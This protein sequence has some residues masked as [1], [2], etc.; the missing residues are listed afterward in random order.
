MKRSLC[1]LVLLS[2]LIQAETIL[3]RPYHGD[4]FLFTQPDGTSFP[5]RLYGDEYYAVVETPDGYTLTRDP[6]T[7]F[8]SYALPTPG[9][10]SFHPSGFPPTAPPPENLS[11]QKHLRL[12]PIVVREESRQARERFGVDDRGRL[13]PHLRVRLRPRDYGYERW[14]PAL[15]AAA[16]A[17]AAGSPAPMAPPAFPTTGNRVGLVL[18][19]RFPDRPGDVTISQAE[20]DAFVNDPG[21]TGFDN[22]TSVYGYFRLQSGGRL[23]YNSI[24]TA[25]FTAAQPRAYYTDPA[26]PYGTRARELINEG[27]AVLKANGFD[28]TRADGNGDGV[29]D[30]VNIFYAGDVVNNWAEGLWPHKSSSSWPGLSGEGVSQAFQYQITHL[31]SSLTLGAYCH[32]NGHMLCDFPDLYPYDDNAADLGGYSLMHS[33]GTIHPP[34]LDAYLKINA[35]WAT[36]IDLDAASHLRGA[37][38]VDTNTFY[39]FRNPLRP[40]EYF[41]VSLRTNSGYEGIYGGAATE[42]NPTDGIVLWHALETGS[43]TNSS[44]RTVDNPLADYSVPYEL[45]VV[46]A[47]PDSTLAR[48]YDEPMPGLNDG[49]VAGGN[50]EASDSTF[51]ALRFWDPDGRTI[52]SGAHV[53]SVS[54]SG[55]AMT[56]VAGSG[57]PAGTPEIGLTVAELTP[58]CDYGVNAAEQSFAIFNGGGGTLSYTLSESLPWLSLSRS[59][60]S[61]TS[62][63]D[64]VTVN[65]ATDSLGAGTYNG[66]I[67]VTG[68]AAGNSP[69]AL[70]V[71]LTVHPQPAISLSTAT[72]STTLA[73]GARGEASFTIANP[74]GGTLHY[75]LSD[76]ASWLGLGASGGTV[77]AE[78]DEITVFYDTSGLFEGVYPAV[79]TVDSSDAANAPQ[80]IDVTLTVTGHVAVTGPDG[81]ETLWRGNLHDIAWQTDGSVT[82]DVRIDLY[83]GGSPAETLAAATP[84]DG[85]F[86]WEIPFTLAAGDDYR[87]R[88]SAVSD[89]LLAGESEG[90]FSISNP[91]SLVPVP[92]REGFEYGFGTW[93]QPADDW[94]DWTRQ[95]GSTPSLNTGPAGA[96]AGNW[97]L[98]VE[99]S[100]PNYPNKTAVLEGFFD[101]R[102]VTDPKLSFFYHMFGADMGSLEAAVS[103]DQ[104]SWTT[105]FSKSGD[106]GDGWRNA[107]ID[108][109]SFAGRAVSIRITG[110]TGPGYTSDIALDTISLTGQTDPFPWYLFLPAINRGSP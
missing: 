72:L 106:Q 86:E 24:V 7:G 22:A 19:A 45:L 84:N 41:L 35:G 96:Q 64:V 89:P 83:K 110:T 98:Y 13:L 29:L 17:I 105:L 9:N 92:S 8:Y 100:S 33:S 59:S 60:G 3:S 75:T 88:V 28:F 50:D 48:W 11:L 87:V 71:T 62:G 6:A 85:L 32:E 27:L 57:M 14:T 61:A 30:G 109:A 68:A 4:P 82:G 2:V 1:L 43:N 94:L 53:H 103:T 78:L 95:S 97:Y 74:G 21:Y 91:P 70:P 12:S 51:P 77:A 47:S 54:A 18:L 16:A 67:T 10:R 107:V 65:Y 90:D 31:G 102:G 79:I 104:E 69:L 37:V 81:G 36:V 40:A 58:A 66:T 101:L 20:V 80:I 56:F 52:A 39:R 5:V 46:E 44:I 38:Q 76:S 99:S 73:A 25:Y 26:Q 34:A 23:L 63:A 108:L 42:V 93:S 15:D 55:E 49:Y